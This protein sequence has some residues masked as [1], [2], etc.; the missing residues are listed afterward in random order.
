MKKTAALAFVLGLSILG[1][2]Q[3]AHESTYVWTNVTP[4]GSHGWGGI[5]SS[6]DGTH[7]ATIDGPGYVYTSTST[8]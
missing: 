4:A 3:I 8:G 6:S 5:T 7:L 1:T 2:T